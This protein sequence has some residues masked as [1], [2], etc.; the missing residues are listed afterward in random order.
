MRST[1]PFPR[2][3][4]AAIAVALLV[5]IVL[6]VR[7]GGR[8]TAAEDPTPIRANP[9]TDPFQGLGV[10]VDLYDAQAWADPGVA[11]ADMAA[12]GVRTLYL[13]TSNADRAQ[14]FVFPDGVSAF[15]DAAAAADVRIVAW[16]L[17]GFRDLPLDRTRS[18]AAIRYRTPEGNAFDGFGLDIESPGVKDPQVRTARLM[19]LTDALRGE[20]GAAYPLGAIVPSPVMMELNPSY[21]P[22]FP[23][24]QLAAQVDAF[25]PMTYYT[26]RTHGEGGARAYA[27][28]CIRLVRQW[29]GNAK[30]PIHLIGGIA[31]DATAPETR[32]FVDATQQAKVLGAS[33]YTWPGITDPQWA[34]L[35]DVAANPPP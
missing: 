29:V 10:W 13:E 34:A 15:V 5:V 20:A 16:Y 6:V 27:T 25:L 31:Q 21:W 33:Y 28:A 8:E 30:V 9:V 22:G 12:N 26:F 7:S 14:A 23:F 35:A 3:L 11:V 2:A 32:G 24:Q 17:P 18:L 19:K 1:A 4:V